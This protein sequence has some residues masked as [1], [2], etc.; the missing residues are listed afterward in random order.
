[1]MCFF[2]KA[3]L[4][5]VFLAV[6]PAFS[7][8]GLLERPVY[9]KKDGK[10]EKALFWI[11]YLGDY[12]VKLKRKFFGEEEQMVDATAKLFL[13]SSGYIVG[14][15]YCGSKG[16]K[17]D[18]TAN[19]WGM[20]TIVYVD[21]LL[22]SIYNY[23]AR[24]RLRDGRDTSIV[25]DIEGTR[26]PIKKME[27]RRYNFTAD[28]YGEKTLKQE[29]GAEVIVEA[30]YFSRPAGYIEKATKSGKKAASK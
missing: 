13:Y 20:D 8:Q 4:F 1:M 30:L 23:G 2:K 7:M 6:V 12:D 9:Y 28:T 29:E 10:M 17:V 24:V 14:S 27:M 5:V 21:S 25:L 18:C 11:V 26:A 15:G 16:K 3:V 19:L 22:D